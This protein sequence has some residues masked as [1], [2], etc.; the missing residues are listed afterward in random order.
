MSI[1][2]MSD[3]E[4]LSI[5]E[6]LLL[7]SELHLDNST[8]PATLASA[9]IHDFNKDDPRWSQVPSLQPTLF[10]LAEERGDPWT[11]I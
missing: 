1:N 6:I 10:R 11:K 7:L 4:A 5:D 9:T 8:D 2:P 3:I